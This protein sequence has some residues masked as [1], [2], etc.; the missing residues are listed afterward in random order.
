M[1]SRDLRP[2]DIA[3]WRNR[4]VGLDP[5]SADSFDLLLMVAQHSDSQYP[6]WLVFTWLG[7]DGTTWTNTDL[8]WS[9][10]GPG[11]VYRMGERIS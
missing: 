3:I 8:P 5:A 6:D 1:T 2:G 7:V 4:D 11:E 10:L 9:D